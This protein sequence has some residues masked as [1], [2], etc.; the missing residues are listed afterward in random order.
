MTHTWLI[1][2]LEYNNDEYGGVIVAHWRCESTD[3]NFRASRYGME[4]FTPDPEDPNFVLIS[5]LTE[6]MVLN[7]VWG[8]VDKAAIETL[9]DTEIENL[10]NPQVSGI[11]T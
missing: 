4:T 10:K 8:A 2:Q 9:N 3:E 11:I 7:W 1:S 6:E 5:D